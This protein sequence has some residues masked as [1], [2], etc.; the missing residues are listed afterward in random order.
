MVDPRDQERQ[1][2][3]FHNQNGHSRENNGVINA[4]KQSCLALTDNIKVTKKK[5]LLL[6]SVYMQNGV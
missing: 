1:P 6:L 3:G 2:P 4:V 5:G